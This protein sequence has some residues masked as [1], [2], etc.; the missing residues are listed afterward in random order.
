MSNS[1]EKQ[2]PVI[3]TT[4][5]DGEKEERGKTVI[6]KI[7]PPEKTTKADKEQEG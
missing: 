1:S 7:P 2:P 3:E 5:R 4:R 6:P